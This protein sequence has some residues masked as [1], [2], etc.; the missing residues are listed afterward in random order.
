M[1]RSSRIRILYI[2]PIPPE[3]GGK[4]SGGVAT[5]CWELADQASKCGYHVYVLTE[6]TTRSHEYQF[7][8]LEWP[9]HSK[10]KKAFLGIHAIVR[11][12]SR[13]HNREFT[14]LRD[15]LNIYYKFHILQHVVRTVKP[16]VI[17]VLHILDPVVF[18][19]SLLKE[20][21]PVVVT[22]HGIGVVFE[23][24]LHR[25][26]GFTKNEH[27]QQ[28]R[29]AV[30]SSQCVVCVSEF[31]KSA[32]LRK[33]GISVYDSL[34]VRAILNPIDVWKWPLL[35][36]EYL[37]REMGLAGKPTIIF[38]G[39]HLPIKKKGLDLLLQAVATDEWLHRNSTVIITTTE[40][41]GELARQ[42][43]RSN[44]IGGIV[45]PPQPQAELPKYYNVGD[46]FV[47]PSRLEGIGLV[48]SEA[49]ISGTPV[50]G[51]HKSVEELERELGIYIGEGFNAAREGPKE[52]AEKIKK[53]LSMRLDRRVLRK[54][55]VEKLS[56]E[57]K[58]QEYDKI[59]R[60]L[61]TGK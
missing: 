36:R 41:A 4:A 17:H 39:V 52:L 21:P 30:K 22:D 37:K 12:E 19:L 58:F 55:V 50:V 59:Y 33:C 8:V 7:E 60:E 6:V 27:S 57:V 40:S 25:E 44:G 54:A 3:V 23:G 53:V 61:A 45:L 29:E 43:I 26:Y 28:V 32:L 14:S 10:L 5:Y 11:T 38:S 24:G 42:Y 47:M 46:V 1:S 13:L 2:G 34:K 56:W 18:S 31:S 15:R 35:D 49:L 16:D 20:R 48:Y 51:F 9:R